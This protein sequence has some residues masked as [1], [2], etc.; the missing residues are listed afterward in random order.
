MGFHD[1]ERSHQKRCHVSSTGVAFPGV[2]RGSR[3]LSFPILLK[4]LQSRRVREGYAKGNAKGLFLAR[5]AHNNF[6]RLSY[7]YI[8]IKPGPAD[9]IEGFS[10]Y[11]GDI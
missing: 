8:Y 6:Q 9:R 2:S 5:P 10:I 4:T 7:I 3:K 1:S 11:V